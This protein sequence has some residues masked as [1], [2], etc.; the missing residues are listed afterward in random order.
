MEKM[1]RSIMQSTCICRLFAFY[2]VQS[3]EGD[4]GACSCFGEKPRFRGALA[5]A[6][7]KHRAEEIYLDCGTILTI[8][9]RAEKRDGTYS[10]LYTLKT[11]T[12]NKLTLCTSTR[13]AS[14]NIFV[15]KKLEIRNTEG[16][17]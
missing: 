6:G 14:Q 11:S 8:V 13:V 12:I 17:G 2:V 16:H 10:V 3:G 5:H 15:G 7:K 4:V 9:L 1:K